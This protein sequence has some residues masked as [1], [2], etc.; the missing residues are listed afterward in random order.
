[1]IKL[2]KFRWAAGV[3]RDARLAA[4]VEREREL[5]HWIPR[6]VGQ[7]GRGLVWGEGLGEALVTHAFE[8]PVR[9]R[10][11][12]RSLRRPSRRASGERIRCR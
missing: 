2:G 10:L 7:E 4:S 11:C 8:T 5:L 6:P 1:M 12:R 3:V 9:Q